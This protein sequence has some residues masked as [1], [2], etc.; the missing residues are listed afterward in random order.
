MANDRRLSRARSDSRFGAHGA[1]VR[2]LSDLFIE[3][4]SVSKIFGEDVGPTIEA[5]VIGI[6]RG[7]RQCAFPTGGGKLLRSHTLT[8][9]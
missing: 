2:W 6:E 7:S 3:S 9:S 5:F 1:C 8:E 4:G